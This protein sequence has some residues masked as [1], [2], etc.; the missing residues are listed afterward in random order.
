MTA[1]RETSDAAVIYVLVAIPALVS[2]YW[3]RNAV[4]EARMARKSFDMERRAQ[5]ALDQQETDLEAFAEDIL[6][7][8][9]NWVH[10]DELRAQLPEL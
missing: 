4:R 1:F 2:T 3:A 5:E 7:H 9:P 8:L 10:A 6:Q